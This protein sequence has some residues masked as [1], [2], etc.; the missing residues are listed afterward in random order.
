VTQSGNISLGDY[1]SVKTQVN[2]GKLFG[3][4]NHA[5]GFSPMP[6]GANK[7]SQ[8]DINKVKAWVDA[9]APNN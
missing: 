5:P 4:I 3:A 9:G 6:Q 2:N 1:T 8:C 7:M